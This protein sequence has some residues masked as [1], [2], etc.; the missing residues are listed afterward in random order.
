MEAADNCH[1][2]GGVSQAMTWEGLGP[3]QTGLWKRGGRT[4]KDPGTRRPGRNIRGNRGE[5][6]G[7]PQSETRDGDNHEESGNTGT[8]SRE[9]TKSQK[10]G[11]LGTGRVNAKQTG[12]GRQR[13]TQ[14]DKN[15]RL[16]SPKV[17]CP[18]ASFPIGGGRTDRGTC[19]ARC[20]MNLQD[21]SC[22][23]S[24]KNFKAAPGEH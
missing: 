17:V 4:S 15:L 10:P 2:A 1:R 13:P 5:G 24:I 23:E 12:D 19:R 18:A 14:R 9:R 3:Q 7:K 20:K 22:K 8:E 21:P 6:S 16:Q 11:S